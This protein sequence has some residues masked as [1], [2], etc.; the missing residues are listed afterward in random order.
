MSLYTHIASY[1]LPF[2]AQF[3]RG[4]L[5]DA[6]IEAVL[7]NEQQVSIGMGWANALGGVRLLVPTSD[8]ER[9]L[10]ILNE[11]NDAPP[12]VILD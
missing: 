5:L 8:A 10:S 1:D 7:E 11:A 12:D 9:A 4:L 2:E 3:M 6:G